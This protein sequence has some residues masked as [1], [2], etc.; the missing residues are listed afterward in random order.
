L[1]DGTPIVEVAR[2]SAPSQLGPRHDLDLPFG[3]S[4]DFPNLILVCPTHHRMIDALPSEYTAEKLGLLRER[5]LDR[6]A[7][8]LASARRPA[9]GPASVASKIQQALQTW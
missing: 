8:I 7:R 4:N 2:I 6:V 5:H 9:V 1:E 3:K